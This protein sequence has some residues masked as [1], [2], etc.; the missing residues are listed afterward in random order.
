M[1]EPHGCS[2]FLDNS[3]NDDTLISAKETYCNN[4]PSFV[5]NSM[6]YNTS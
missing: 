5:Y 6:I 1:V 4:V 2:A 3:S